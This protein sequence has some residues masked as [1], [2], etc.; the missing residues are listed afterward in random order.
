MINLF[1]LVDQPDVVLEAGYTV[2]RV[3]SDTSPTGAFTT[4]AGTVAIVSG[5]ESVQFLD[6]VGSST[7]WYKTAYYGT[8]PGEGQK[9]DAFQGDTSAA[10]ASVLELRRFTS[11]LLSEDDFEIQMALDAAKVVIDGYCNRPRGFVASSI[12]TTRLYSGN[13]NSFLLIDECTS[14]TNVEVKDQPTNTTY[15]TWDAGDWIACS[16]D[17]E[18]PNF[19]DT[20][21]DMIVV[22]GTG[23]P[24]YFHGSGLYEW[25]DYTDEQSLLRRLPNVRITATWGYADTCP[26]QVKLACM[27][28]AT[29]WI[30]RGA[31]AWA[32]TLASADAGGTLFYRK[33]L[34]PDI[35]FMLFRLI[36]P[37]TGRR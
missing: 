26:A 29:R 36:K 21:Y 32:D 27:A 12:A 30:K 22:S 9:S 13:S 28:Q 3:Y 10:Y 1:I 8:T 14:V 23:T 2:V 7:T 34:D 5:N 37:T 19:N 4:L 6:V 35:Q 20:P 18:M 17:P 24:R 25:R 11:K 16:G 31:S 15:T 33:M